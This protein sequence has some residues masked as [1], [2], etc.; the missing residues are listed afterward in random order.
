M[1]LKVPGLDHSAADAAQTERELPLFWYSR[2]LST[3][4]VTIKLPPGY[5]LHYAP[6]DLEISRAGETYKAAFKAS[7]GQIKF[8]EEFRMDN[9]WIEPGAYPEYKAFKQALAQ[10]SENWIVLEK[11]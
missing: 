11:K 4:E 7:P 1:I 6:K 9:T 2:K 8:T 5:R 10:L 3:R